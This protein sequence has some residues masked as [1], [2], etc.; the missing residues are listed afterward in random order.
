MGIRGKHISFAF[1]L[2]LAAG[3]TLAATTVAYRRDVSAENI[4]TIPVLLVE[5]QDTE[6]TLSNPQERF[7][8]LL[9]QSGPNGCAADYFNENFRGT[10]TFRF[11][12]AAQVKLDVPIATYGAHSA[13]FNDTDITS[14]LLDACTAALAQGTDFS[15]FD[16]DNNGTI[17]NIVSGTLGRKGD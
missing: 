15:Q 17:E 9:N 11:P 2:F 13:T 4:R 6:F 16:P 8:T 7:N 12:T 14:L 10:A 1:L 3:I 5:F